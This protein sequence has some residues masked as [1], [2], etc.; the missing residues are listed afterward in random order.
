MKLMK[1]PIVYHNKKKYKKRVGVWFNI[2]LLEE[3]EEDPI[4]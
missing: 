3:T 1:S 4:C 2:R